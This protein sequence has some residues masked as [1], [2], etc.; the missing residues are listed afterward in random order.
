M[1]LREPRGLPPVSPSLFFSFIATAQSFSQ[2]L[3]A[4][5]VLR[6]W[7]TGEAQSLRRERRSGEARANKVTYRMSKGTSPFPKEGRG[8]EYVAFH[9]AESLEPPLRLCGP[10]DRRP[11]Y[12]LETPRFQDSTCC[13]FVSSSGSSGLW[14]ATAEATAAAA[15][16][17]RVICMPSR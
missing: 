12:I 7:R 16:Q 8:E 3:K 1:F 10:L 4:L 13:E 15:F 14:V 17:V 6:G 11:A 9:S 2:P 5:P